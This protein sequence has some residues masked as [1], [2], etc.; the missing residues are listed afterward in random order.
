MMDLDGPSLEYGVT[1]T[2]V[3][4]YPLKQPIGFLARH[5]P[6]KP[7]KIKRKQRF[8]LPMKIGMSGTGGV[9]K[10]TVLKA[11]VEEFPYLEVPVSSAR[12]V[13]KE[14]GITEAA[15]RDMSPEQ[16]LELQ[17]AITEHWWQQQR[18][19][20]QFSIWDRTMLDHYAYGV[21][22]NHQT[23]DRDWLKRKEAEVQ[24]NLATYSHFFFFPQPKTWEPAPDPVRDPSPATRKL[25]DLTMEGF[26][27]S[28][29]DIKVYRVPTDEKPDEV[30]RQVLNTIWSC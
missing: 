10:T 13:F 2:E 7:K 23:A 26:L 20:G 15:Q 21:V 12:E 14:R 19:L 24:M 1:A 29:P 5:T 3:H 28:N 27:S 22:R 4:G 9:G 6:E 16:L 8:T 18:D 11:I 25:V 17:E 30:V